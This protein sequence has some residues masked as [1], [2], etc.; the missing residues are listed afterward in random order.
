MSGTF[1]VFQLINCA[2]VLYFR[3][4][5]LERGRHCRNPVDK[6]SLSLCR[7]VSGVENGLLSGRFHKLSSKMI[8]FVFVRDFVQHFLVRYL[9]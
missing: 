4:L 1:A 5:K 8:L 6:K 7:G 9:I 2:H 3:F